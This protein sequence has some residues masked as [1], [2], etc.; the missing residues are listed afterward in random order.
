MNS[1]LTFDFSWINCK[2][3]TIRLA[4]SM[5]PC[6]PK[7]GVLVYRTDFE[8]DFQ[9]STKNNCISQF[10]VLTTIIIG[11]HTRARCLMSL[12]H[13]GYCLICV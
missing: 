5:N 12:A 4:F 1:G 2:S 3:R 11:L 10:L 13:G 6:N 7:I 8:L 9:A